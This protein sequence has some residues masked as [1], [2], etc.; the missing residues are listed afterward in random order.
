VASPEP[1]PSASVNT[2][3][4]SRELSAATS[5]MF[6]NAQVQGRIVTCPKKLPSTCWLSSQFVGVENEAGELADCVL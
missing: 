2:S 5:D 3:G 1:L 4:V 6:D